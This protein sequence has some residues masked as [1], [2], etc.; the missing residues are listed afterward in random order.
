M[1]PSPRYEPTAHDEHHCGLLVLRKVVGP[2]D[3]EE[4]GALQVENDHVG[5]QRSASGLVRL[6][7]S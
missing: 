1:P 6:H 5:V 3:D 2:R 4:Q 7:R